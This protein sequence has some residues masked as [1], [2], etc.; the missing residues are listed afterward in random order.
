MQEEGHVVLDPDEGSSFDSIADSCFIGVVM[1]A[2]MGGY[3]SPTVACIALGVLA[4]GL[5]TAP[6]EDAEGDELGVDTPL[7]WEYDAAAVADYWARRWGPLLKSECY[8]IPN[9]NPKQYYQ[10]IKNTPVGK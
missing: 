8:K 10:N 1:R 6:K 9:R 2:G 7:P 4:L 3:S 5:V